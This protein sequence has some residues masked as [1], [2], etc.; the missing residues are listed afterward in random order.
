MAGGAQEAMKMLWDCSGYAWQRGYFQSGDIREEVFLKQ[1]ERPPLS[2]DNIEINW[3]M[4]FRPSPLGSS[5][6]ALQGAVSPLVI[7]TSS[8]CPYLPP[9]FQATTGRL[10]FALDNL[11]F[12]AKCEFSSWSTVHCHNR[13]HT[14]LFIHSFFLYVLECVCISPFWYVRKWLAT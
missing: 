2:E 9:S 12:C 6:Y 4:L 8:E 3:Q 5:W 11:L 13:T 7:F 1:S 14:G 10:A